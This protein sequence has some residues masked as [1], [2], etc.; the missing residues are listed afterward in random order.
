MVT[1]RTDRAYALVYRS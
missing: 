1:N